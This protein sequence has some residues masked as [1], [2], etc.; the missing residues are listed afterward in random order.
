LR[1]LCEEP[2]HFDEAVRLLADRFARLLEEACPMSGAAAM[3]ELDRQTWL[4]DDLLI[5]VD[6]MAMAVSLEARVPY[7]DHELVEWVAQLPFRMKVRGGTGKY[8]LKRAAAGLVPEAIVRRR[9][10]GFE[11]PLAHWL[12]GPMGTEALERIMTSDIG[13]MGVW[14]RRTIEQWFG[15]HRRGEE[16]LSLLLWGLWSFALWYDQSVAAGR[17]FDPAAS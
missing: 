13:R 6:R 9:K 14:K 8:L 12:R 17:R 4:P 10:Q 5:K 1:H 15:A 16:D 7:L 2:S 3:L 11:P